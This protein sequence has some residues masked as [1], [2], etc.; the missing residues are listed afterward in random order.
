MNFVDLVDQ[1]GDVHALALGGLAVGLLFGIFAQRSQFCLRSATI[2]FGN[3]KLNSKVAI[4]V[5]AFSAAV[6]GTQGAIVFGLLDVDRARQLASAGS[7]SGAI[8]G[9]LLFGVGMILARGC[10]SRVLVLSATGN[11]RAFVTGLILTVVAQSSLRGI[12]APAREWL[13]QLWMVEGG[14]PRDALAL[15]HFSHTEAFVLALI[16]LILGIALALRA[17]LRFGQAATSIGVGATIALGWWFTYAMSQVSFEP[18]GL[19]SV[20]FTGPSADTLMA[21]IN[22]PTL[23]LGFDTGLVP[24]VFIGALAAAIWANEFRLQ[25]FTVDTGT[26]RYIV[27]AALMGFGGMLAGGCAVGAGVTG[28]SIFALTA[29]VALASMWF[30]A[31]ATDKA[32]SALSEAGRKRTLMD[33]GR[34]ARDLDHASHP[35]PA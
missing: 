31:I 34:T 12:L 20:S 24:G 30:S 22:A 25:S 13:S 17:R 1:L 21:L 11:M 26:A 19:A 18:I 10:A 29:W 23:T 27:G 14:A 28:S 35:H 15:L 7:M 3:F 16:W 33:Q 5:L 9:G 4:W 6:A 2:A 32:I 8:I